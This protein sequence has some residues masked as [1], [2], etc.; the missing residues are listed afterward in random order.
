MFFKKK[1]KDGKIDPTTQRLLEQGLIRIKT[2]EEE[3]GGT[4]EKIKEI[5]AITFDFWSGVKYIVVLSAL[6]WWL[7]LF[8]PMLAGYVGGRRTGGPKKGL[9]AAII[10]L[11]VIGA[12]H[13]AVNQA[14]FPAQVESWFAMPAALLASAQEVSSLAPYIEFLEM[15]WTAFFSSI[16]GG[17]PYSPN[18]YIITGIFAYI[19]GVIAVDKKREVSKALKEKEPTVTIDVSKTVGPGVVERGWSP[20]RKPQQSRQQSRRPV[21]ANGKRYSTQQH[22]RDLKKIQ[23]ERPSQEKAPMS[24]SSRNLVRLKD[25]QPQNRVQDRTPVRHHSIPEGDD[26]EIL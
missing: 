11:V 3:E 26:W 4:V 19:G 9:L 18:S 12:V 13:F 15:Y 14:L 10:G 24:R 21:Q 17:L 5:G 8:G 6:L 20:S 25:L 23:F 1:K 7:P 16:I 2:N 22:L